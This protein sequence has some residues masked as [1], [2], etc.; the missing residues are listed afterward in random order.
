MRTGG[1]GSGEYLPLP[2]DIYVMKIR[3]A[4]VTIS[5]FKDEK[6]G[7]DQ[8][9]LALTWEISR[10]T[11]E[12]READVD[13]NRWVKQWFSLFYGETKKGP[14]KIKVFIDSLRSQGL[15]EEFDETTGEIDSDWFLGIEQRVTVG[16]NAKGYNT[17]VMVSSLR[18]K[19]PTATRN[20]PQRIEQAP[21]GVV[22][23]TR[24]PKAAMSPVPAPVAVADD[25][26]ALFDD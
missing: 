9:Q 23:P 10:L 22:K 19:G 4:D 16:V 7:E 21:V 8:M 25:D 20:A 15:L 18:K 14:S 13:E 3:D 5:A 1:A 24:S 26:E 11:E 12:Q 6:T 2:E 17:V